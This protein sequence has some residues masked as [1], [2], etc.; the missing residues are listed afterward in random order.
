MAKDATLG[1]RGNW[2][3]AAIRR[4]SGGFEV[5]DGP[6]KVTGTTDPFTVWETKRYR[7]SR[8]GAFSTRYFMEHSGSIQGTLRSTA[9]AIESAI[10]SI[11]DLCCSGDMTK[12][13]ETRGAG[14]RK[15]E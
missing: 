8:D 13:V 1:S 4:T 15:S 5:V 3:P 11:R 9:C 7:G 6:R 12:V 14:I 10:F 2:S